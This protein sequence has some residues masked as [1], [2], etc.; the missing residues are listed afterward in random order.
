MND[1]CFE[2]N[3]C[4][5]LLIATVNENFHHSKSH[6]PKPI[7]ANCTFRLSP[8][9][10]MAWRCFKSKRVARYPEIALISSKQY[11]DIIND[12]SWN[13]LIKNLFSGADHQ[14]G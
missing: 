12:A 10:R 3:V 1:T 7:E 6:L 11:S 9:F 2:Q 5:E 4:S 13:Q 8:R 14:D